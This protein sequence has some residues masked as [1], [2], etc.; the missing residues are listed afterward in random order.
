MRRQVVA[1]CRKAWRRLEG[2]PQ[3]VVHGDPAVANIRV[4]KGGVGFVDWDEA[5]VDPVDHGLAALPT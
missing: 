4:A 1:A 2:T 5:R 3:A